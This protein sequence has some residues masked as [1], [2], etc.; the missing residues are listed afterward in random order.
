MRSRREMTLQP[1]VMAFVVLV[2]AALHIAAQRRSPPSPTYP[3]PGPNTRS[4]CLHSSDERPEQFARR[5][6]ALALIRT[7]ANVQRQHKSA[8][9]GFLGSASLRTRAEVSAFASAHPDWGLEVVSTPVSYAVLVKDTTD[10]C[11]FAYFI[12]PDGLIYEGASVR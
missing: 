7:I 4:Q 1:V 8:T 3:V 9:G 12:G 2:V 5:S 11:G 6:G 10:G